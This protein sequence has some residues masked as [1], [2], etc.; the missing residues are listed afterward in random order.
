MSGSAKNLS[1]RRLPGCAIRYIARRGVD[2]KGH[3]SDPSHVCGSSGICALGA[4]VWPKRY[5]TPSGRN[6]KGSTRIRANVAP[7]GRPPGYTAP[8]GAAGGAL[9]AG[10]GKTPG[11]RLHSPAAPRSA[12]DGT[13]SALASPERRQ[14]ADAQEPRMRLE[15]EMAGTYHDRIWFDVDDAI[16]LLRAIADDPGLD[17]QA[18]ER[19][20]ERARDFADPWIPRCEDCEE[21]LSAAEEKA[22]EEYGARACEFHLARGIEKA[23]AEEDALLAADEDPDP[24]KEID[25]A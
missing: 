13:T 11:I 7:R 1:L 18:T 8:R 20:R 6:V 2:V 14:G 16:K 3:A 9:L 23:Q 22:A 25:R 4:T 15:A 24:P 10:G 17:D 5:I 19:L 12:A 21:P